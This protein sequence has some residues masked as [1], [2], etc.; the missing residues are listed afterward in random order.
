LTLT[1]T[2]GEVFA[3]K[4]HIAFVDRQMNAQTG[5]IRIAAVFPNPGNVLRP[6]QFGRVTAATEVRHNGLLI[7]Q[8]A[9]QELQGIQQV[10]LAGHDGKAHLRTVTL[11]SQVGKSWLVEAGVSPGDMVI[12]DNLQKLRD[13][14]PVAPHPG[15]VTAPTADIVHSAGK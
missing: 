8:V 11:G 9:I 1:L 4:G 7:P 15:A 5:A 2:N 3:H 12:T 14:A 10:Y 13:E 6:G